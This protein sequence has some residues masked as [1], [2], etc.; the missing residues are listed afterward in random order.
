MGAFEDSVQ[1]AVVVGIDS[2]H[3]LVGFLHVHYDKAAVSSI[4]TSG[5]CPRSSVVLL[6]GD[7]GGL[8]FDVFRIRHVGGRMSDGCRRFWEMVPALRNQATKTLSLRRHSNF[9]NLSMCD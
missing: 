7:H 6:E 4:H 5:S 8:A 2:G 1:S 9:G 3:H